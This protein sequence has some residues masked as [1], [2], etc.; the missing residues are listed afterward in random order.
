MLG[1]KLSQYINNSVPQYLL[2]NPSHVYVQL[3]TVRHGHTSVHSATFQLISTSFAHSSLY[4]IGNALPVFTRADP[5][6][7]IPISCLSTHHMAVQVIGGT[8]M[9]PVVAEKEAVYFLFPLCPLSSHYL[10]TELNKTKDGV[11]SSLLCLS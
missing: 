7:K 6:W 2:G 4:I 1:I 9:R 11:W 10:R 3:S 8:V 5:F